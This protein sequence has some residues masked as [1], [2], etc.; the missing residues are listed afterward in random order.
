MREILAEQ[1]I[2]TRVELGCINYDFLS[3]SKD[4]NVFMFHANC[5]S[6]GDLDTHLKAPHLQ[7]L[8]GQMG[9]LLARPVEITFYEMVSEQES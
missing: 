3:D 2:P 1:V 5:C 6:R 8:S 9:A 4:P 7:P